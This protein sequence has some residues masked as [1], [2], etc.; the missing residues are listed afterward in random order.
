MQNPQYVTWQTYPEVSF[1][2]EDITCYDQDSTTVELTPTGGDGNYSVLV[3]G[4]PSSL[5]SDLGPG[6]YNIVV[7]DGND[8]PVTTSFAI[9]QPIEPDASI[10]GATMLI[11]GTGSNYSIDASQFAGVSIDSVVWTAN[12]SIICDDPLSC[13]SL[14]QAPSETT[15]YVVS[16]F[17]NDGC[18]VTSQLLV[19][20][21]EPEPVSILEVPNVISPNDDGTN[22]EWIIVT[23]DEELV[24]NS[25]KIYDRWGNMV[26][27]VDEAFTP[28]NT[29][30][31]WDGRLNGKDII[32]GVYVYMINF[33]QDG[34]VKT[35]SGDI[36]ILR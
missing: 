27:T 12:D 29:N 31:T 3:N 25:V 20:V 15:T 18:S 36:T 6:N 13:F 9:S 11:N 4:N 8:C 5:I 30:I 22:D 26:F 10:D 17:Y 16:V 21:Q 19:E 32:P 33:I 35:R 7:T 2:F 28:I 23:N 1:A 24:I 14:T 34:R